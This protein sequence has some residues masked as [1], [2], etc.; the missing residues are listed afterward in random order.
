MELRDFITPLEQALEKIKIT[1]FGIPLE[2]CNQISVTNGSFRE[3]M[4]KSPSVLLLPYC[5]KLV[6]CDLRY[7]KGCKIC[8]QDPCS[9]GPAW[10]L[11]RKHKLRVISITSYEDLWTELMYMKQRGV[12]AFIGCCCQ[13]FYAKHADDFRRSKMPGILLDID[14]TTCYDL[15]QAKEAYAG[16]FE[17]QTALDLDLL[18]TVLNASTADTIAGEASE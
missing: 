7:A 14:N 3:I 2:H 10:R 8:G 1:E 18:E 17:S 6:D 4:K 11:G 13:P 16:T 12:E 9:I 5:A 15:D